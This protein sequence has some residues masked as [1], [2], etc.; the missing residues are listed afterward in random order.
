MEAEDLY[1]RY[2]MEPELENKQTAVEFRADIF[3]IVDF[4]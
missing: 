2:V 1:K 4:G 3:N